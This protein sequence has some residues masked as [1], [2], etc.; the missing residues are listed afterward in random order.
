MDIQDNKWDDDMLNDLFNDRDVQ[1]IQNI[2]LPSRETRDTWLWLFDGNGEFTVRSCY[3]KLVGECSTL[4]AEFWK[5]LWSLELPGKVSFFFW[6]TCRFCLPTNTA[7]IDKRVNVDGTCSW[8]RTENET[9]KHILFEC[10]FAREVWEASGRPNGLKLCQK[11]RFW[12]T[13]K[14]CSQVVQR[15]NVLCWQLY[16]GI[17][18]TVVIIGCGTVLQGLCLGQQ[19]QR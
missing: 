18:G 13:L 15:N 10:Q 19:V 7:L 2:P 9:A 17:S 4:D 8:C 12:T 1:L 6:R 3:S 11:S 5:K 16:V 14:D